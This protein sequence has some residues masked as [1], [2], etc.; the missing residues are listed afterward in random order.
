MR[1][2][3]DRCV[4]CGGA[5]LICVGDHHPPDAYADLAICLCWQG[6]LFRAQIDRGVFALLADRYHLPVEHVGLVEEFVDE[7][8]IPPAL[9]LVKGFDI[10]AAGQKVG[11]AKL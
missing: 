3:A 11:R 6:R 9:R 1:L 4:L 7:A 5:G 10:G 2:S 8:D